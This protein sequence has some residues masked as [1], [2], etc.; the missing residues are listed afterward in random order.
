MPVIGNEFGIGDTQYYCYIYKLP[1][2]R[3][4]ILDLADLHQDLIG[5]LV[6]PRVSWLVNNLG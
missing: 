3:K 6:A 1:N 5:N 4:Q 2:R